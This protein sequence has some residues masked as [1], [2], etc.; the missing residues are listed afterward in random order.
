MMTLTRIALFAVLASAALAAIAFGIRTRSVARQAAGADAGGPAL[1]AEEIAYLLGGPAR[2]AETVV[3]GLVSAQYLRTSRDG[4]LTAVTPAGPHGGA[5][6]GRLQAT[7]LAAVGN[8]A[9]EAD[10][11]LTVVARSAG[12]VEVRD[13]LAAR[14]LLLPPHAARARRRQA[15]APLLGVTAVTVIAALRVDGVAQ[16]PFVGLAA[17]TMLAALGVGALP[18]PARTLSGDAVVAGARQF[19]TTQGRSGTVVDLLDPPILLGITGLVAV[20]GFPAY[21]D[22]EVGAAM[23]VA[24]LKASATA[25]SAGAWGGCGSPAGNSGDGGSG[26]SHHGSGVSSG[27]SS[28]GGSSSGGCGGGGCGGGG[29]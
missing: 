20:G 28:C 23:E 2:L 24:R 22:S 6:L 15:V 29:G 8:G 18:L 27:G 17:A 5:P 12:A 21:P 3:A 11:V 1:T 19:S 25:E 16:Y 7:A 14:H 13:R 10:G 26:G 9:R 4:R